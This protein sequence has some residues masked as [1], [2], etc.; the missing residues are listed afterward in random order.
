[1]E[2][3]H[4]LHIL[5]NP[6]GKEC[7]EIRLAALAAANEIEK[8]RDAFV[9]MRDWAEKCGLEIMTYNHSFES[10]EENQKK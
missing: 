8:W 4:I 9:N 6:Y 2:T 7:A 10:M 3:N 5:R 1:M